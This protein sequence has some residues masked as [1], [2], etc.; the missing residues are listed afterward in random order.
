[1]I[2]KTIIVLL[3]L[4]ALETAFIAVISYVPPKSQH[5]E[6]YQ[7]QRYG[8]LCTARSGVLTFFHYSCPIC[9]RLG[10]EHAANCQ[11]QGR[12]VYRR[13]WPTEKE[14][15]FGQFGWTVR[16]APDSHGYVLTLP[17]W[18]PFILFATYPTIAVIRG[19]FRRWRRRRQGLCAQCGYNLT[20]NVTGVCPE[21]GEG[22][23][24][25]AKVKG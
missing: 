3:T 10:C 17:L 11:N 4:A 20:G 18:A 8:C 15:K 13:S 9:G 7:A 12:H 5:D 21:C 25:D 16:K 6:N 14:W 2:R 1:M 23:A 24:K 22:C 19:P